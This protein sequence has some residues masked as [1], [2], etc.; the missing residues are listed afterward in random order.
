MFV[1]EEQIKP[2]KTKSP[3]NIWAFLLSVIVIVGLIFIAKR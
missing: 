2:A 1:S 3:I